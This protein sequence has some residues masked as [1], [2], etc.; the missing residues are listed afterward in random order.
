MG[1]LTQIA[2]V[3]TAFVVGEFVLAVAVGRVLARSSAMTVLAPPLAVVE[4]LAEHRARRR[5]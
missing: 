5:R 4:D 3:V 2:S 1:D